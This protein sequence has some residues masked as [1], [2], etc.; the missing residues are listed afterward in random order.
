MRD[1]KLKDT[2][3]GDIIDNS[4]VVNHIY[5]QPAEDETG[6]NHKS[7]T[8]RIDYEKAKVGTI[9]KE[10]LLKIAGAVLSALVTV[11]AQHFY[12]KLTFENNL[13]EK[14]FFTL[15]LAVSFVLTVCILCAVLWNLVRVVLLFKRGKLVSM[16]SPLSAFSK[17]YMKAVTSS[18][19]NQ[20]NT[21]S[22][23]KNIDGDI[24]KLKGCVCPICK[25][26]PKGY[27][28]FQ[29][30]DDAKSLFLVCSEEPK[31]SFAFDHKQCN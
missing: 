15:I 30:N 11:I 25:S 28:R 19:L 12:Q 8:L 27:M 26:E 7:P 22:I 17:F 20:Y 10:Q 21:G 6:E 23:Y 24:F 14:I 31:H 1:L 16:T 5:P 2:E 29:Y 9:L 18:S 13:G 3:T 4:V